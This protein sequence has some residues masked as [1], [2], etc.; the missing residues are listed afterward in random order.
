MF[1][2]LTRDVISLTERTFRVCLYSLRLCTLRLKA[3][4]RSYGSH[5]VPLRLNDRNIRKYGIEWNG[6]E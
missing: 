1:N 2:K 3:A 4:G 6:M 5:G